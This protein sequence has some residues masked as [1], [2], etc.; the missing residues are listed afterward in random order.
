MEVLAGAKPGDARRLRDRLLSFQ[1][2]PTQPIADFERA[3]AIYRLCRSKGETVRS[4]LDCLIAAVALRVGAEVLH[5]DAD[6][7]V[8]SRHSGLA[9]FA[10]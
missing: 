10:A 2:V 7:D 3:A 6:F 9:I 5:E 1:L 8:I 4:L